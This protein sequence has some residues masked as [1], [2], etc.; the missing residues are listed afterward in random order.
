[1]STNK[2]VG[3]YWGDTR[4]LCVD[5]LSPES[6]R[7]LSVPMR[8][9]SQTFQEEKSSPNLKLASQ[10]LQSF[11]KNNRI[12]ADSFN[13]ALPTKDIIFRSFVIPWM[14][15]N[16]IKGVVDFEASKYIP[17]SLE[18]LKYAYH[19]LPTNDG[20]VKRLRIIFVAIRNDTLEVYKQILDDASLN[21]KSIEP[22]QISLIRTLT[23]NNALPENDVCAI[24][25]QEI[26]SGKIT[27]VHKKVPLF[28]REFQ[29]RNPSVNM[30]QMQAETNKLT[31]FINEIKISLDYFARQDNVLAANQI[32]LITNSLS[33][34]ISE[35]ISAD[36]NIKVTAF[37]CKQLIGNQNAGDINYLCAYGAAIFESVNMD[38]DINFSAQKLKKTKVKKKSGP[39]VGMNTR[40]LIPVILACIAVVSTVFYLTQKTIDQS[41]SEIT[42]LEQD[43]GTYIDTEVET[44]DLQNA[45]MTKKQK[46]YEKIRI[47]ST[48]SDF[49]IQIPDL[50]PK[51][52]WLDDFQ[53]SYKDSGS[54]DEPVLT[55]NGY[56]YHENAN[57]QF[58]LV[59]RFQKNLKENEKLAGLFSTIDILTTESRR[60]E[61]YDVT[62]FKIKCK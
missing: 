26:D 23:A 36:L 28:V 1:M 18:E 45:K 5:V 55:L 50:L 46:N 15:A 52:T 10:E 7:I 11:L 21:I 40:A 9:N 31:K 20:N 54:L 42:Q 56:V 14:P 27:I 4:I 2:Q 34:G 13:L 60:L 62:Y 33:E 17:F 49:L 61:D 29:I 47:S 6:T 58:R 3:L 38:V 57:E 19:A 44:I 24:V 8:V 43:L 22:A 53:I 39:K 12:N 30:N 51:G 16:E 48:I 35:Q 25:E 37:S 32:I 41:Q 59:Y